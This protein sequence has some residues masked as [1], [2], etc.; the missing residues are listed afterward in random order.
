MSLLPEIRATTA[1]VD[2]NSVTLTLFVSPQLDYF[3]GHFPGFPILPGV[4]QV[5]W[6]VRLARHYLA[7]CRALDEGQFTALQSLKFSAP[8]LPSAELLLK[9]GWLPEKQRLE[10]SYNAGGRV[11]SSGQILFAG[12]VSK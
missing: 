6:V 3:A 9:L 8:V 5:D 12:A 7:S 4:V 1:A 11:M 10:F 2:G